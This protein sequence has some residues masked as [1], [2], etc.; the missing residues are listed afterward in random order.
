MLERAADEKVDWIES[1]PFIAVH[2][3]AVAGAVAVGVTP[4]LVAL[5]ALSYLVRMFGV[6]AGYHRYFA[7]R[8]FKTGRVV[9]FLFA[10]LGTLSLQ[11]GVLWWAAHHRAHHRHSDDDQDIHSPTRRGFW[12]SHVGWILARKYKQTNVEA[13]RD[14]ARYPELRWLNEHYLVPPLAM[15]ALVWLAFGAAVFVWVGLVATVVLWHGTFTI[16]S[17]CHVFGRRRY[18][19]TD[20][21]KNSLVLALITGGEGWHNNHH[22]YPAS[23]NQGFFWWEID[24]VYY[25]LR[26]LAAVGLV[27]DLKKPSAEVLAGNR[28]ASAAAPPPVP[29][30]ALV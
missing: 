2:V 6:T 11:K 13:I 18:V 4:W 7:H 22:Y 1:I 24:L 19:T 8:S 16:N 15:G 3:A 12:W 28:V 25:A 27:W 20:T 23:A 17:L 26:A 21:S 9:Q 10:L 29:E 14:F 30:P 5:A